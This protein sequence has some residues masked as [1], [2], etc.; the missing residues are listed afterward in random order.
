MDDLPQ[1]FVARAKISV[2]AA[3]TAVVELMLRGNSTDRISAI[4]DWLDER[5]M[6]L[7]GRKSAVVC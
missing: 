1:E 5:S 4:L 7:F 6:L 3:L 2:R